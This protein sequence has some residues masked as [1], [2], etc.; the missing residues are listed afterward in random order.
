MADHKRREL[1]RLI[2]QRK[3]ALQWEP[4]RKARNA[5][6]A[7]LGSLNAYGVLEKLQ[8]KAPDGLLCY[9]PRDISGGTDTEQWAAA[10]IWYRPGGYHSYK[11]LHLCGV[12]ALQAKDSDLTEI[13]CGTVTLAYTGQPYNP[14]AYFNTLRKDFRPYYGRVSNP[15]TADARL[16]HTSYASDTRLEL[17][18]E[19]ES[20]LAAWW[21]AG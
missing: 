5:L 6:T 10:V 12:W 3:R 20:T 13:I 17:R 14:E 8:R 16:L 4:Q 1:Q 9:G 7:T 18:R 2:A 15:P 11:T 21:A 19:I